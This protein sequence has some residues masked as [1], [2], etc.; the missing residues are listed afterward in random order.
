MFEKTTTGEWVVIGLSILF[1]IIGS[2][3][4]VV[5]FILSLIGLYIL[6]RVITK[7]YP[8]SKDW[9]IILWIF[10]I[11]SISIIIIFIAAIGAAFIYG[12]AGSGSNYQSEKYSNYGLSFNHPSSIQINTSFAGY[13]NATYYKGEI[14]FGSPNHP[15]IAIGWFPKGNAPLTQESVQK[16]FSDMSTL[17]RK[18]VP[19]L[20]TSSIQETSHS[21]DAIYYVTGGGHDTTFDGKMAYFVFTLWEDPSSQRD[22]M[23]I[24]DS[25]QNQEDAQSLF[26]GVLNSF[27]S[28]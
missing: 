23:L 4:F 15:E 24:T 14:V 22:F 27:E 7:V 20:N 28:H 2:S 25:Y 26:D 5:V 1:G 3:N 18:Q 16:V 11:G 10:A 9:G 12:L 8:K 6:Y 21:G 13:S 19:D 17:A